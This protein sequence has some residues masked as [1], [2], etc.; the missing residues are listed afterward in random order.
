MWRAQRGALEA[1]GHQVLAPDLP[2]FG[3][4]PLS[5]EERL[6][7]FAGHARACLDRAKVERA[8]VCGLSMGGYVALRLFS[9]APERFAGLLLADTKAAADTEQQ[10]QNRLAQIAR[11]EREGSAWLAD[12]MI[13]LLV[14]P[15]TDVA[16]REELRAMMAEARP[17]AVTR[18]LSAMA[19]RPDSTPLLHAIEVPTAIVVGAHD[20]LTGPEVMR[21]LAEKIPD[22]SFT[23]IDGVGHLSN[24]EAPAEFNRVLDELIGRVVDEESS[25]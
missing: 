12:E 20:A 2:G 5:Q 16:L 14:A 25:T 3:A 22:A 19:A 1:E 21:V 17:E 13:P 23:C 24:L 9:Q 6:S 7:D 18:A 15:Q 11:I 4:T 8:V 10:R